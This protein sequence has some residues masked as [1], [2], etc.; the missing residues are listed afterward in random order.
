M[1]QVS[2]CGTV[3]QRRRGV[4][5]GRPGLHHGFVNVHSFWKPVGVI[6]VHRCTRVVEETKLPTE[7]GRSVFFQATSMPQLLEVWPQ[8]ERLQVALK[9]WLELI[10]SSDDHLW[11]TRVN[12]CISPPTAVGASLRKDP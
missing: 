3:R 5:V 10:P 1:K 7:T 9:A 2:A 4:Q 12:S 11:K 8:R 6:S